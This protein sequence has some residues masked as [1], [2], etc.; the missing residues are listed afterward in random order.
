M[1]IV[2]PSS[3]CSPSSKMELPQSRGHIDPLTGRVTV[4]FDGLGSV[5]SL[6]AINVSDPAPASMG[7][8]IICNFAV[9]DCPLASNAGV[10]ETLTA[11]DEFDALD[12]LGA[13]GIHV[14]RTWVPISVLT[15]MVSPPRRDGAGSSIVRLPLTTE[16]CPSTPAAGSGPAFVIVTTQEYSV[17]HVH[18]SVTRRSARG[19]EDDEEESDER[20]EDSEEDEELNK[21]V[22][23]LAE[24]TS[25]ISAEPPPS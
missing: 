7:P 4:E 18:A 9:T 2:L 21:A 1:G 3:H 16:N 23:H 20:D 6:T 15:G 25:L 12:E 11:L 8:G 10:L 17:P 13:G 24:Q 22:L 14:Q 5:A 19:A